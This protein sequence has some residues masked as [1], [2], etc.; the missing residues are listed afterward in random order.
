MSRV[1]LAVGR[2]LSLNTP[3]ASETNIPAY[4]LGNGFHATGFFALK[5]S[6]SRSHLI[7]V[8]V[9]HGALGRFLV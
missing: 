2:L 5:V 3:V 9:S 8:E 1:W 4:L 6:L 7:N